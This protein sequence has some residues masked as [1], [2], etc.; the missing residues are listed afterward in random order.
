MKPMA[1]GAVCQE[2][3]KFP[4]FPKTSAGVNAFDVGAA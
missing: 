1:K 2:N 4:A 3:I